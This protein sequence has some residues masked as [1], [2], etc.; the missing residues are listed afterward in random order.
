M[1]KAWYLLVIVLLQ[2]TSITGVNAQNGCSILNAKVEYPSPVS[3]DQTFAVAI[4][5]DAL[6]RCYFRSNV[7]NTFS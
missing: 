2:I 3:V 5:M 1:R 7:E 6:S 4:S